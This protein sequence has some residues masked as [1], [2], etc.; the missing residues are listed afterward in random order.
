MKV[1]SNSIG[2]YDIME[3]H[4]SLVEDIDKKRAPFKDMGVIYLLSPTE[5]SVDHLVA[6]YGKSP[7][8]GK[9]AFIYF[10]SPIPNHELDKIKQCKPLLKR[11]KGLGEINIDFTVREERAYTLDMRSSFPP[12]YLRNA[13]KIEA[14]I[15]DKLVTVCATLNEYPHIRYSNES[16]SCSALARTFHLKMDEFLRNNDQ[17]WYHGDS[18]HTGRARGTLLL[19]DRKDDCLSPLMHDFTYQAMVNDLLPIEDDKISYKSEHFDSDDGPMKVVDKDVLL[20]DNDKLW[21]ELR[22][23]HIADVIQILSARLREIVNSDTSGL[24]QKE[25]GKTMSLTQMANALKAL[26]E[27]RE[28]M[29]KLSQHMHLSHECMDFFKKDGLLTLSEL[30]QTLATGKREDGSTPKLSD[31]VEEVRGALEDMRDPLA[32]ARLLMIFIISQNGIDPQYKDQVF[33]SAKLTGKLDQCV[34]NLEVL[35]I[36]LV[37]SGEKKSKIGGLFGYVC[38]VCLSACTSCCIGRSSS[39]S[40]SIRLVVV[41]ES[42]RLA[43]L[44]LNPSTRRAVTLL[45]SRRL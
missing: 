6:D 35:D 28:V 15:A 43:P 20:N 27:Y 8:Y 45:L 12:L 11:L 1:V 21:V 36:P 40:F 37:S 26:P 33:R 42:L 23:K 18:S 30:E 44:T 19:L 41:E 24:S 39:L 25:K 7:L 13:R 9:D 14:N 5:E 34:K 10:L 17:W 31:M 29:S 3:N 32:R 16:P 38:C 2:M 4:V 22:S